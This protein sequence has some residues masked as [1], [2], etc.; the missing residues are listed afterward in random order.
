MFYLIN[1]EDLVRISP[2][3][4]NNTLQDVTLEALRTKYEGFVSSDLGFV[5]GVIDVKVSSIGKIIPGDGATHHI[6]SFTLLSYYPEIQGIVEGEVVEV[7][8]FGAFVR[9]GPLDALIHVSQLIDDFV[10]FDER[11]GVL[12]AKETRRVLR[13]GD[14]VRA[15][16][17]AVSLAKGGSSGKIGMTMRQP[18]LGKM[19]WI[20]ED[21]KKLHTPPKKNKE[22]NNK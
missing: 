11:Q 3:K 21:V 19:E 1:V 10:S 13:R 5:V 12:I 9:I 14:I 2:D 16:I 7:E 22:G 20:M 4:F 15:R 8:D 18:F 17:T 6:V